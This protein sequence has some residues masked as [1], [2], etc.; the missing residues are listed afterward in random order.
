MERPACENTPSAARLL[1]LVGCSRRKVT[2][3]GMLP[4]FERYDGPVFRLLRR[5]LRTSDRPIGIH[6][7]SAAYGL[8]PADYPIPWYDCQMTTERA[9]AL[10]PAVCASLCAIVNGDSYREGFVCMGSTYRSALPDIATVMPTTRMQIASG[11]LGRQLGMLHDW[12]YGQPPEVARVGR[13][14]SPL[15]I[16]GIELTVTAR[17]A[18][19]TARC[20]LDRGSGD[21]FA[22]QS[23]YVQVDDRR[24]AP[25]WLVSQLSGLPVSA[26]TTD[27]AR[28]V[29]AKI[30]VPVRRA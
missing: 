6:I 24:V 18:L 14:A 7:L 10:R 8:I 27:E 2:A 17:E 13:D 23:W 1:V 30:G 21:P 29:L 16:R 22:F 25:K 11:S 15:R 9:A 28:R 3:A 26:F 5:F 4:A 19:A 20:E 12:L